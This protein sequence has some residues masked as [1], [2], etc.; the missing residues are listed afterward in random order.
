MQASRASVK[1]AP[2]SVVIAR[3][4]CRTTSIPNNERNKQA[5]VTALFRFGVSIPVASVMAMST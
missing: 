2:G 3:N 5:Q 4:A 1:V